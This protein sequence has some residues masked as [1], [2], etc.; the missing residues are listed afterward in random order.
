MM[1]CVMAWPHTGLGSCPSPLRWKLRLVPELPE[2]LLGQLCLHLER[3]INKQLA[4]AAN[5]RGL[6]T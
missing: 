4:A 1:S 5:A 2:A 6:I 3:T